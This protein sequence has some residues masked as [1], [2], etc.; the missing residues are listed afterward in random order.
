[1]TATA[2]W[3]QASPAFDEVADFVGSRDL[4]RA[5]E[6]QTRYDVIDR[7]I[8]D[9]L[10]WSHGS[11]NVEVRAG[12]DKDQI[13]DYT[14]TLGDDVIVVE[15]KRVGA[16]FPTPTRRRQL[17]LSGSVLGQG[18]VSKAIAQ[19]SGYAEGV[20]ARAIAVTNGRCWVLYTTE[21]DGTVATILFP[22]D[23]DGDAESLWTLLAAPSVEA[24]GLHQLT[25]VEP[26]V[27]NRLLSVVRDADGRVDRNNVADHIAPALD[28]AIHADAL[29]SDPRVLEACY[30]LTE[31]RV[32]FDRL[33]NVHLAEPK[34][35]VVEPARR[36][37][38]KSSHELAAL[39]EEGGPAIAPPVTLII[40]PVGAGKSTYLKHFEL[41]AGRELLDQKGAEWLYLDFERMGPGVSPRDFLYTSLRARILSG[42]LRTGEGYKEIVEPA[43]SDEVA[44]L[45]RGPLALVFGDKTEFRKRVT[46]HI[47]RD[48]E[49]VEPYVD[50]VLAYL[51]RERLV[52]IVLDNVDLLE[53][54]ELEARVFA[55]GLALSKRVACHV[56]VSIRDRTFARHRTDSAFDAYELKKLW[57]DPP[58][59][60]EVLATRLLY[61]K[62]VLEGKSAQVEMANGIRLN[63]PDLAVFFDISQRSLLRGPAGSYIESLSDLNIRKGLGLVTTFFNSGHIQ[64]DRI[65]KNY[66]DGRT[67]TG[68]PFHE[69][70][71]GTF[72]GQWKH[73]KE[74]RA[75]G[76]NLFDSR[77][78]A[79]RTRLARLHILTFLIMRAADERTVEV[80][81]LE[82]LQLFDRYGASESQ[83]TQLLALLQRHALI[84]TISAEEVGPAS[85][86]V[87]SRSG[88]YYV[89]VLA[90]KLAYVEAAMLDTA[91]EDGDVWTTLWEFTSKIERERDIARR[92]YLRRARV[93]EFVQYLG[94]L[95][96]EVLA[97]RSELTGLACLPVIAESVKREAQWAVDKAEE[98]YG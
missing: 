56:I 96:E 4:F 47:M 8:R 92:M 7:L 11:V 78:G 60:R 1:M 80:P 79:R 16:S 63:V 77:L 89:R 88:S 38:K 35:E 53:D 72:L 45:A 87:I 18:E 28:A 83:L 27:E 20:G 52:V 15:A 90:L 19:A 36:I 34:P 13:I 97:D 65:L 57:L 37:R 25:G 70:F 51:A 69:V 93:E 48:F 55:E 33:L 2:D 17:S 54:T 50:K 24:G 42:R 21:T 40:G 81:V 84:R 76:I 26:H 46:D 98:Y 5:N 10:G 73:Y 23:Q 64:A 3:G 75:E 22:F 68:F 49:A 82:L 74:S 31:A 62:K 94:T 91:I 41:L 6:A 71:K 67:E 30:V 61:A 32:K 44:A 14:L 86:V 12:E 43:Y 59:F 39:V 95:E 9:V 58:P 85:T 66:L 29:L